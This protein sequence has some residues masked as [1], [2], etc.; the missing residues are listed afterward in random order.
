MTKQLLLD[1]RG[2]S[3]SSRAPPKIPPL[4]EA[5]RRCRSV[6][7]LALYG[8]VMGIARDAAAA[9]RAAELRNYA[10][11]MDRSLGALSM[12]MYLSGP[13]SRCRWS[14]IPRSWPIVRHIIPDWS[15][16]RLCRS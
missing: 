15:C 10:V 12:G 1:S 13:V 8:D 5:F 6:V 2:G 11:A 3:S 14:T 9:R 16:E 4:P 7:G